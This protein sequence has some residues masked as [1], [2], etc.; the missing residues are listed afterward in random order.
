ML[1][2]KGKESMSESNGEKNIQNE[3]KKPQQNLEMVLIPK[4]EL[5]Q[6]LQIVEGFK[7]KIQD[8]IKKA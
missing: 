1:T 3:V 8:R 7:R 4:H 2:L 6:I 5:I